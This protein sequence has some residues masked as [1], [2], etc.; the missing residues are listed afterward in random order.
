MSPSPKTLPN[1]DAQRESEPVIL[2]TSTDVYVAGSFW[3][4]FA[5]LWPFALLFV[6]V[7]LCGLLH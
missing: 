5:Y 1:P 6:G 4:W 2:I 3:T 7:A